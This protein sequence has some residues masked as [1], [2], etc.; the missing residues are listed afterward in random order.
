MLEGGSPGEEESNVPL[1]K[2]LGRTKAFP[3]VRK[4][5]NTKMVV[6]VM[7]RILK[8]EEEEEWEEIEYL[9]L[10]RRSYQ[11]KSVEEERWRSVTPTPSSILKYPIQIVESMD[12]ENEG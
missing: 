6:I 10:N 3:S 8:R 7:K 9:S 12:E 2:F 4:W 11:S 1:W 5:D